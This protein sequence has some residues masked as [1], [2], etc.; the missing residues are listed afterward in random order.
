MHH[1]DK[2]LNLWIE[3]RKID[4]RVNPGKIGGNFWIEIFWVWNYKISV[5]VD[6]RTDYGTGNIRDLITLCSHETRNALS[7]QKRGGIRIILDSLTACETKKTDTRLVYTRN[8]VNT[9]W[10]SFCHFYGLATVV[11]IFLSHHGWTWLIKCILSWSWQWSDISA[12]KMHSRSVSLPLVGD[13]S[14]KLKGTCTYRVRLPVNDLIYN[15]CQGP[16][17]K[18]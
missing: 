13:Y 3:H 5:A 8:F 11:S 16:T 4:K 2:L 17:N 7:N 10:F 12:L 18:K 1:L 15:L 14:L 6:N 9:L